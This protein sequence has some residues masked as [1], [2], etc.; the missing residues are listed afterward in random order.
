MLAIANYT[1]EIALADVMLVF[2]NCWLH[3]VKKIQE[4][5]NSHVW[6]LSAGRFILFRSEAVL[7]AQTPTPL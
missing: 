2:C 3:L 4:G 6:L 7:D 5:P 1:P